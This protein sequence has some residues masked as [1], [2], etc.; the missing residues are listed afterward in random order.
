MHKQKLIEGFP[1]GA[2]DV[3]PYLKVLTLHG[4]VTYFVGGDNYIDHLAGDK[5]GERAAW[6]VLMANKH[7]RPVDIT[8]VVGIPKRTLMGWNEKY[9]VEG[10]SAFLKEKRV[11]R[12]SRV[13]TPEKTAE[14][15]SLLT[16]GTRVAEVARQAGIG[17]STLRKAVAQ[18]RV[19]KEDASI[20]ARLSEAVT[21]ESS[22]ETLPTVQEP[23]S[24]SERSRADAHAATGIGMACTR[25]DERVAVAI[26]VA[27]KAV[28]RFEPCV[29]VPMGGLLVGMPALCANG[30]LSGLDKFLSLPKGFY[31]CLHILFILGFMALGRIRRPEN[32][33]NIPPGELG[34]VIG[35]D[36]VP[37][38][39][40][41][42]QK[43]HLMAKT[44]KP[45]EWMKDLSRQ[46]MEE[47][48]DAAGY[49]YIDGHVRV[50]HGEKANPPRRYVSRERLCLRG[51]TDYWINDA[52]GRPFF[53]VSRTVNDGLCAAILDE[54]VPDLL[55]HVPDQPSAQ[56]LTDNPRLHRFVLV[57]DREGANARFLSALWEKRIGAITYR[58][59][60]TDA[61][62]VSDFVRTEVT[63]PDGGQTTM[64]LATRET[65]LGQL[66]VKEVRRLTES[67]HQTSIISTAFT[68]DIVTIAG[69]MFARWCQENFF[70]YMM[71]H[72]EI[73]GLLQYGVEAVP[74]TAQVVN[75]KWREAD[76]MVARRRTALTKAQAQLGKSSTVNDGAD[77]QRGAESLRLVHEARAA[78]D[79]ALAE[80]KTHQR[81]VTLDSLP[82]AERPSALPPLSKQLSD[83]VKMIAYRSETALVGILRRYLKNEDEARALVRAVLVA[84]ADI[85]PDD[86][87]NTL[88]IRLHHMANPM[89]DRAVAGLLKELTD[90]H[91]CHPETGARMIYELL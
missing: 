2:V 43:I 91:F 23:S 78:L 73:D 84:S 26:G 12:S 9:A 8:R 74:G 37:E 71:Q 81:K 13:L 85:L 48:P 33:R 40:T 68:L 59:N 22:V 61:W 72:Y 50:Y 65:R 30:L 18:K 39:R 77:A 21:D 47:E 51:T 44:G 16:Q 58:K 82:Q 3:G 10:I 20:V 11:K 31:S 70:K 29:D 38:V 76:R 35:L 36:R 45:G 83:A 17:E 27:E 15:E 25:A 53:V 75:P 86:V 69:R 42:R 66:P 60:I 56:A 79:Q 55:T 89:Q 41:L 6:C 87:A 14:C 63:L 67:G 32:L 52:L 5:R 34:K 1:D 49:L 54:I 28:T 4:K 24:K 88:T 19:S 57:F 90:A 46:W 80:R 64:L 7:A 62:P